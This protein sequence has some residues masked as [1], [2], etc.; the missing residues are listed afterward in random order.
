MVA[1]TVSLLHSLL[2]LT[3]TAEINYIYDTSHHNAIL[4]IF[5]KF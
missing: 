2:V 4:S 1:L 5:E 3:N